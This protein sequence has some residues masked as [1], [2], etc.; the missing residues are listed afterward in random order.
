[1]IIPDINLL[2]TDAAI[3][4]RSKVESAEDEASC[5]QPA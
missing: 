3:G 4:V 2:A 1:M 5:N